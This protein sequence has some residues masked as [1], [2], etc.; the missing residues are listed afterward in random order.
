MHGS[1][2]LD[3]YK[4]IVIHV[5]SAIVDTFYIQKS[6]KTDGHDNK[7]DNDEATH[8]LG[9]YF[10]IIDVHFYLPFND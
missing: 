1:Q 7:G 6:H 8:Q 3:G 5:G 10:N 4:T 9:T 2:C